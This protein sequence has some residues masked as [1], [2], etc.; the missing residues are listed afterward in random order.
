MT[1]RFPQLLGTKITHA[2][3]GNAAFTLD[4]LA[5]MGQQNG[6]HYLPGCNGSGVAMMGWQTARKIA[7]VANRQSAFDTENFPPTLCILA[8]PGSFSR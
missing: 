8:I 5:H 1:D 3:T 7:G 2:W 4:A 6:M